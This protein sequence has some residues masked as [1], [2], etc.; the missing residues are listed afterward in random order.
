M[1]ILINDSRDN[2]ERMRQIFQIAGYEKNNL[3]FVH[4]YEECKTFFENQLETGQTGLDLIITNNNNGSGLNPYKA[5]SLLVL[6]NSL[7]KPFSNGNFRINSIPVILYSD[8]DDKTELQSVGFDAIV[9]SNEQFKHDYLISVAEAQIRK[10]REKLADDLNRLG[11]DIRIPHFFKTLKQKEEY[12]NS[13]GRNYERTFYN[14]TRVVSMEFIANPTF[15]NYDWLNTNT[16]R[17]NETL[18]NFRK[19]YRYHVKY[20]RKNNERTVIHSFLRTNPNVL[21]RDVFRGFLYETPL[22]EKK[23]ETQICDFILQPDL[24]GFQDTTF[25]EVKKEDVQLF[26]DKTRKRP[27]LS[28]EMN[29]HLYQISDYQDYSQDAENVTELNAKLGYQTT[30]FSYQLL[31]GRLEEKEE[32]LEEFEHR[33][34]KHYP[35]IEVLTYEDFEALNSS[36]LDKFTRLAVS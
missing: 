21:E 32:V 4:S 6:R 36:Y 15:L 24:P 14:D 5:S 19:M 28:F 12:I 20:D 23:N 26:A 9:K 29:K 34:K 2:V 1:K 8:A 10:W 35:G 7:T 11:L 3:I 18:D 13:F 30:N 31:V 33:L 22:K 25:F 16:A 17:L 27:R